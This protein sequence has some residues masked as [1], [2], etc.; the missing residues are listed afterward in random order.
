MDAV[1][2]RL[3]PVCWEAAGNGGARDLGAR[4]WP[5]A[6]ELGRGVER[7]PAARSSGRGRAAASAAGGGRR[8]LDDRTTAMEVGTQATS[9]AGRRGEAGELA[10]ERRAAAAQPG[11]P[12]VSSRVAREHWRRGH[13]GSARGEAARERWWG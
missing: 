9:C 13:R 6:S 1:P 11:R 7:R 3:R 12:P 5:A 2:L 10:P 8:E 4:P